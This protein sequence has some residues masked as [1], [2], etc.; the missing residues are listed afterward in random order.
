[1]TEADPEDREPPDRL[2]AELDRAVKHR[3]VARPVAEQK[4]VGAGGLDVLPGGRVGQHHD[5][6]AP[7]PQGAE[8]VVLQAVVDHGYRVAGGVGATSERELWR[9]RLTPLLAPAARDFSDEVLLGERTDPAGELGQLA[10]P[11]A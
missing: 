8:S 5:P 4:A 1:M 7:R 3:G 11:F 9:K 6:K 2:P 10:Q